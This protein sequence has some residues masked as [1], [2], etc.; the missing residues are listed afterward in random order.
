MCIW[1]H[2]MEPVFMVLGQSAPGLRHMQLTQGSVQRIDRQVKAITG[3]RHELRGQAH[4]RRTQS[5]SK[6][7]STA[8]LVLDHRRIERIWSRRHQV[9][10]LLWEVYRHMITLKRFQVATFPIRVVKR[11]IRNFASATAHIQIGL[12]IHR[13]HP[14]CGWLAY[15]SCQPAKEAQR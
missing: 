13:H 14:G 5:A 3:R 11:A 1:F 12:P 6:R 15:A 10:P 2:R 8:G 9:H 4:V 7:I